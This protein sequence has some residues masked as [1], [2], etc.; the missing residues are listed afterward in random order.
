[1]RK[2]AKTIS[3]LIILGL[4]GIYLIR[5]FTIIHIPIGT[6]GVRLQEYGV[7]GEKGVV[8]EDFGPG[9]HRDLGPIDSWLLFDSTVQ[10]LEMTRE[11]ARGDRRG[12][13]DVRVQSADGFTVSVDVTVKYRITEG[14][15]HKLYQKMGPAEKYKQ[16]VRN[17]AEKACVAVFGQMK[18]EDFY[19]PAK[20]RDTREKVRTLLE[21]LKEN[22]VDVID[23]LVRDVQFDPQYEQRILQKKLADQ[24]AE[25]NKSVTRRIEME[26]KTEFIKATTARMVKVIIEEKQAE[27]VTMR[28]QT[29]RDIAKIRADYERYVTEKRADADLIAAQNLNLEDITVSTIDVDLLDIDEMATKL[30]VPEEAE[31]QTE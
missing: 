8:Q 14:Q 28:A 30:G 18:T 24:D 2:T 13:D 21:A 15:A 1:M 9:W 7:L 20:R 11:P 5:A 16:F 22:Y 27:I 3:L 25:L 23:V 17:A 26:Q 19:N 31:A 12:R 10:T 29:E 6:V 4:V